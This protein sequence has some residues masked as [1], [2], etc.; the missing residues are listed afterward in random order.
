MAAAQAGFDVIGIEADAARTQMLATGTSYIDDVTSVMLRQALESGRYRPTSSYKDAADFS[1]AVICVPTPLRDGAPDLSYIQSA[2]SALAPH[3]TEGACVILESTT[4]P[5][6]TEDLVG[7]LLEAGSGWSA[8]RD[9]YLGYSPERIDPGNT[10]F[11]LDNTPKLVS[12]V[13]E[14]SLER[15]EWFYD[16]LVAATVRM[17][18][19]REAELAK[20]IEN[21]FRHVNIA[22]VNELAMFASQLGVDVW[23][24]IDGAATKPFGYMRFVP[25]PGVGGHCLPI[26]PSFLSWRV[27]TSLGASFRFVELANDINAHMPDYVVRRVMLAL[28]RHGRALSMASILVLGIAYKPNISDAR[29]S[30]ALR[31]IDLLNELGADVRVADPFVSADQLNLNVKQIEVSI[32]TVKWADCIVLVSDHSSFDYTLIGKHARLILDTRRRM[33]PAENVEYL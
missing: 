3:L 11:R 33:S 1:V 18:S 29:E 31:I 19:C 20:L 26:D 7:P 9:F 32:E 14:A 2:A 16:H 12:G 22:L 24:A 8:G 6:T 23:A 13:D 10:T 5:G 30:P 17:P 28:N 21:T 27:E 4:Y 15:V 25:G